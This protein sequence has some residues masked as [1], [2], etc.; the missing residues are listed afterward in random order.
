MINNDP[1]SIT[2]RPG[3]RNIRGTQLAPKAIGQVGTDHGVSTLAV[4]L[5][6]YEKV[7]GINPVTATTTSI[8]RS[9]VQTNNDRYDFSSR[10]AVETIT[11]TD[12]VNLGSTYVVNNA[13]TTAQTPVEP[14]A[15]RV[16]STISGDVVV[17]LNS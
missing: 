7:N 14:P 3:A 8:Q 2:L 12:N 17:D 10:S 5:P 1:L 4:S 16:I 11:T 9:T 13:G 15:S 6:V